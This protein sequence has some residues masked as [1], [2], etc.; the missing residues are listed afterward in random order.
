[1]SLFDKLSWLKNEF[2]VDAEWTNQILLSFQG[3]F[4]KLKFKF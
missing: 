2:S 3:Q 4:S 1:M